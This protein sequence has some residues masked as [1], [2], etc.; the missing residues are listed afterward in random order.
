M[1]A[2][3]RLSRILLCLAVCLANAAW[4][5]PE[6]RV[7]VVGPPNSSATDINKHGTVTGDHYVNGDSPRGFLNRGRGVIY[8]GTFGGTS[9]NAVAIND[10][11]LVLGQWTSKAGQLRG[12][13]Y[14]AGS[15]RDIGVIRGRDTRYTDI[16]DGGYISAHST[17]FDGTNG[18]RGFLRA[19]DGSYRNIGTLPFEEPHTYA[20]ALN[21]SNQV[22]GAS[23]P[24]TFPDQ[25]MRA[26]A[27]S[28]GVLKDLGDFGSAPN[29]AQAIN[30]RGQI[31]GS[32]SVLGVFRDRIAY[33][34]SNGRL[35]DID[36]RPAGSERYSAGAGI[37]GHGHVVG[38]SDHLSGFVYRG[39]RM[40]SLN[41][42]IDPASRWNIQYPEAINDAGQ[43]AATA[44]RNGVQYAVR[45]DLIRPLL[46]RAPELDGE[47]GEAQD[48]PEM[49]VPANEI[50]HPVPQ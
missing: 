10:R 36:R 12:M 6:Y 14:Q 35:I 37:N 13:L 33:V 17:M 18:P 44:T 15:R 5:Y 22:V 2:H 39:R 16:N 34:Y 8:L 4:A 21:N 3:R 28:Q 9:S 11:G 30:A 48:A 40:Q 19:P 42:L 23:G 31:T 25:P 45:L 26:V 38:S 43:I 32:M 29:Y 24:L 41:A 20:F 46:E 27:W 1:P 47:P 7:T 50:V 49:E